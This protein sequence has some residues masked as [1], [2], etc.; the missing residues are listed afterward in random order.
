MAYNM[1]IVLA[2]LVNITYD[3]QYVHSSG[4]TCEHHLDCQ[5]VYSTGHNCWYQ[6]AYHFNTNILKTI[7]D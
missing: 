3:C 5:Y 1:F 2:S 7:L 6:T 4:V